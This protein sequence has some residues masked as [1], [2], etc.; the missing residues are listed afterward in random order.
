MCQLSANI[1]VNAESVM[2]LLLS[3]FQPMPYKNYIQQQVHKGEI[4]QQGV[5]GIIDKIL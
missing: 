4:I 3:D 2:V 1:S 5:K